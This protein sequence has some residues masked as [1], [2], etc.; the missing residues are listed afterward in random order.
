MSYKRIRKALIE[1]YDGRCY[2]CDCPNANTVD[3]IIPRFIIKYT[4]QHTHIK[5]IR[6]I[7]ALCCFECNNEMSKM[8]STVAM[9][10]EGRANY[11]ELC[12]QVMEFYRSDFGK[13]VLVSRNYDNSRDLLQ[14]QNKYGK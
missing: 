4:G 12:K 8:Q 2:I 1:K 7:T 10:L 11:R 13:K 9:L 5:C 6:N 3:H 14:R